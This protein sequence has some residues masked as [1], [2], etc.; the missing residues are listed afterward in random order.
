MVHQPHGGAHGQATDIAIHAEEILKMKKTLNGI[1][2][3][4][5]KQPIEVI[6]LPCLCVRPSV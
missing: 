6:G 5:S 4:H 3:A 2:A 1:L